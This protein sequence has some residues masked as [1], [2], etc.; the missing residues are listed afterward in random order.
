[1]LHKADIKKEKLENLKKSYVLRQPLNY[2]IQQE[3]RIDDLRKDI[4]VRIGHVISIYQ[5][6]FN[7]VISKLEVLSP[8]S[9]LKR[10]YSITTK[11]P[12]GVIVKDSK[13]LK[14]GDEVETKL[15]GGKF[16]SRVEEIE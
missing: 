1:M 13:S 4:S 3:Q 10:G 6:K 7:H 16:K 12:E 2:I 14:K 9:I 5:E 15:G 11:L 8:V